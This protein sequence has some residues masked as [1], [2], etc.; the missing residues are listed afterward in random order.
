V[1]VEIL[2]VHVRREFIMGEHYVDPAKWQPLI[3]NFRHYF[4]LGKELGGMFRAE[5]KGVLDLPRNRTDAI[6]REAYNSFENAK[7]TFDAILLRMILQ[8]LIENAIR[9]GN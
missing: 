9:H 8:P 4:S 6:W 5:V 2:R 7:E 1:E 3:Y